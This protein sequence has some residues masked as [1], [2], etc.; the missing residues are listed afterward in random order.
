MGEGG[1]EGGEEEALLS[2]SYKGSVGILRAVNV[3]D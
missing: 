1:E 3:F 2:S